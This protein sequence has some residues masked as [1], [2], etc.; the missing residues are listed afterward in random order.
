MG[1][2][3]V[4]MALSMTTIS[5][6][7]I[8]LAFSTH[9]VALQPPGQ[10]PKT[11]PLRRVD[12][13]SQPNYS[14]NIQDDQDT[15]S[16]VTADP[17]SERSTDNN[18]LDAPSNS[19]EAQSGDDSS[20]MVSTNPIEESGGKKWLILLIVVVGIGIAGGL[21]WRR[22]SNRTPTALII[23]GLILTGTSL[24]ASLGVVDLAQAQN[25]PKETA[26]IQRTI[27]EV[28]SDGIPIMEVSTQSQ[29]T[30]KASKE[31]FFGLGAILLVLIAVGGAALY[32][33]SGSKP[34]VTPPTPKI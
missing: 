7:Q 15:P 13:V 23:V 33:K 32:W 26:P 17:N 4:I 31:D 28:N 11:E 22:K 20:P 27:E 18:G 25:L 29:A 30:T 21:Y 5:L 9:A 3:A 12:T 19:L 16:N 34:K 24:F 10:F 1:V 2:L 6:I 14:T 8:T